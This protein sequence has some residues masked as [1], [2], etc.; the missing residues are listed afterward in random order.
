VTDENL[1][2]LDRFEGYPYQYDRFIAQID[3]PRGTLD[4]WVYAA[5]RKQPFVPP[6]RRYI[7]ILKE[8]ALRYGFPDAYVRMLEEVATV[9]A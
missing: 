2:E 7:G 8:A 4:A 5:A 9:D 3:T 6:S 1:E